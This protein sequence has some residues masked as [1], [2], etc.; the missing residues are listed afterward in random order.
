MRRKAVL[1]G[2]VLLGG[3]WLGIAA[4]SEDPPPAQAPQASDEFVRGPPLVGGSSDELE[5]QLTEEQQAALQQMTDIREVRPP[6]PY[7]WDPRWAVG[8]AVVGVLVLAVA[9]LW[10]LRRRP[11]GATRPAGEVS[12]VP[13]EVIARE[14]LAALRREAGL[15]D[16]E[17]YF[18]LCTAVRLYLDGRF[19]A[20][21]LERT[22]EELLPLL[23]SLPLGDDAR[24]H[25]VSLFRHS[26]PIRYADA[27]ADSER[28]RSDLAA[29]EALVCGSPAAG[30]A[31]G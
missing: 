30:E 3:L 6:V 16:K 31:R 18:R 25:L 24:G 29:A 15:G 4:G 12:P 17:F 14:E 11:R 1:A 26:D 8:A 20:A 7:G 13:P 22:T 28:R 19:G 2:A 23:R 21:T 27:G 9:L 10:W 5:I